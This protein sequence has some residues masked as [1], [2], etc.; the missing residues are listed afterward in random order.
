LWCE[1]LLLGRASGGVATNLDCRIF[2]TVFVVSVPFSW[3]KDDL[4]ERFR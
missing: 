1:L 3:A 2:Q 4:R